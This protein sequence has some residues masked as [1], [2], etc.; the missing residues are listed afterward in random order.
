MKI[1]VEN[2]RLY[3]LCL[4]FIAV[5][6]SVSGQMPKV[7]KVFP[8]G[9]PKGVFFGMKLADFKSQYSDVELIKQ[10]YDFR[11]VYTQ[12]IDGPDI[13]G[14]IYYFDSDGDKPL[15]EVMAV[16]REVDKPKQ[17][18]EKMFGLPNYKGEEWR[19]KYN[20]GIIWSWVYR[21][22][23]VLVADIPDTEWSEE[24]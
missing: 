15:Y 9:V 6:F 4:L 24:F 20:K 13:S 5:S 18:A 7:K 3:F 21:G 1:T 14:I 8:K 11:E 22:K 23:L 2:S 16:Y 10:D 19:A 12:D 17:I